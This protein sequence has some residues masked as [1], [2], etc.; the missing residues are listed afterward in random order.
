MPVYN[1]SSEFGYVIL[2]GSAT[3]F[4]NLWQMMRIGSLRKKHGIKYPQMT[5][6]KHQDFNCAQRV[7]QNTLESIPF[8]LATLVMGGLRHPKYAAGFGAAWIVGRI[9]YSIG[10]YSGKPERRIPGAVISTLLGLFP[11]TGLAIST[12]AGLLGWW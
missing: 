2:A 4:L 5:S 11:L 9:I 12:G 7:H 8:I 3:V 6:D 10:Y 1:I